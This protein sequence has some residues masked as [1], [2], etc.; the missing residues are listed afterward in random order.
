MFKWFS[1]NY[2][3]FSV[4]FITL[5]PII[6]IPFSILYDKIEEWYERRKKNVNKK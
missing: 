3:T 6:L 5:L 4:I 2:V 1:K